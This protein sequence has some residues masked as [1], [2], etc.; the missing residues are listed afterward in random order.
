MLFLAHVARRYAPSTDLGVDLGTG[1]TLVHVRGKGVVVNEPSVVAVNRNDRSVAAVGLEAK[2]MLGRTTGDVSA[3]HPLRGGVIA[4]VDLAEAMLRRFL[5]QAVP[6]ARRY[7]RPRVV[8]A[9]PSGITELERRAVRS[10]AD[11]AGAREVYMVAEPLAAALGTGV[12]VNAPRGAMIVDV[13]GGTT[14]IAVISLGGI[15][16]DGSIRIGGQAMDRAIVVH[17]R[18]QHNLLIGEPTA[19]CMKIELACAIPEDRPRT[20]EVRGRDLVSGIPR[21]TIVR[22]DEIARAIHEPIEAI[23][24]AIVRTLEATPPELASDIVDEGITLTGGGAMIRGLDL[25]IHERT[26]V[27]VRVAEDPLTAVVRG[28]AAILD[29]FDRHEDLLR[30]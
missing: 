7:P 14:D 12:E 24:A 26:G 28:T 5:R 15:V 6:W 4:D 2:R 17:T 3:V 11:A 13:G 27:P 22:S 16:A 1:N 29:E 21:G 20:M 9:V 19:E 18:R 25:L 30:V 8:V 23:V 10:S